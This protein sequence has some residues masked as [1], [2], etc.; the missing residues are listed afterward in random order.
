[1][2]RFGFVFAVIVLPLGVGVS[3]AS[4][5]KMY[6]S[7]TG[8][9]KVQRADLCENNVENLI[10]TGFGEID[11]IA[12]DLQSCEM[13]LTD[14]QDGRI[15]RAPLDGPDVLE[16]VTGLVEPWGIA[17]DLSAG[18]MYWTDVSTDKIQRANL[19]GS[20]IEDLVTGL[21]EPRGIDLDLEH[22]H[23]YW[24]ERGKI[25][26]ANLDGM[27]VVSDCITDWGDA[28]VMGVTLNVEGGQV[29]WALTD[30]G[31]GNKILRADLDELDCSSGKQDLEIPGVL[32][33]R[34]IDLDVQSGKMY[35]AEKGTARIRR[36]DLDGTNVEDCVTADDGLDFPYGL[37]LALPEEPTI[38][39]VS[40]WG[41]VAMAL[42]LLTVGTLLFRARRRAVA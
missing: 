5:Q 20:Y 22:G 27:G 30:D 17:L 9:N 8:T 23:I 11:G 40:E 2:L 32:R 33:P 4:A 10:T 25:G 39:T 26:R 21:D 41:M 13:Y 42:L 31:E 34:G 16:L 29:Y 37:A 6:W 12:L 35:W 18:K 1:M 19:D 24:G 38:P 7:D 15:L 3:V 28:R 36:A 14:S